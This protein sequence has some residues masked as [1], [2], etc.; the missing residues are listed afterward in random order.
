MT[1]Q[2]P[3]KSLIESD[4]FTCKL[5]RWTLLLQEYNFDGAHRLGI[6]NLDADGL[7]RSPSPLEEHITGARW[8]GD[9]D[10]DAVPG[11]YA[12]TYLTLMSGSVFVLPDQGLDE[13]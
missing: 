1:D 12:T 7:S 2:K 8:H 13:E 6:T 11:W 5:A 9:C 3:L 4:K 10:R